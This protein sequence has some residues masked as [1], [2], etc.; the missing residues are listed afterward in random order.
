MAACHALPHSNPF[1]HSAPDLWLIIVGQEHL[2]KKKKYLLLAGR[3]VAKKKGPFG[4][5][6]VNRHGSSHPSLFSAIFS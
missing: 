1:A 6:R 4:P 3:T 5:V 2:Q